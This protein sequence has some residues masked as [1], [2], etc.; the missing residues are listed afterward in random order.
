MM[1]C[2]Q[3]TEIRNLKYVI[4]QTHNWEYYV[5]N[6]VTILIVLIFYSFTRNKEYFFG[7]VLYNRQ[8]QNIYFLVYY[9]IYT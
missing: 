2:S 5:I 8:S 3:R 4:K 6:E 7:N 1:L 9:F